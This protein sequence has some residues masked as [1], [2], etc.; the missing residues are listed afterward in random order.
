MY[1]NV[2]TYE[3]HSCCPCLPGPVGE[4]R[5]PFK[6]PTHKFSHLLL[7]SNDVHAYVRYSMY[8]CTYVCMYVRMLV[9]QLL[10]FAYLYFASVLR[11]LA[12]VAYSTASESVKWRLLSWLR[13]VGYTVLRY[14]LEAE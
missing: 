5:Q 14:Q 10:L 4:M 2:R 13:H 7:S 3:S 11:R 6:T 12:L 9:Y 8:V 1:V